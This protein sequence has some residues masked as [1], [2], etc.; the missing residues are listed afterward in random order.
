[1]KKLILLFLLIS[2]NVASQT[3]DG[4]IDSSF[5]NNG[6]A[7]ANFNGGS[8]GLSFK[9][10]SDKNII[11]CGQYM[12]D[13]NYDFAAIKFDSIGKID[14]SFGLNGKFIY[15]FGLDDYANS[16]LIQNDN[17]IVLGGFSSTWDGF[18]V[19]SIFNQ[20]SLLRIHNN[21][22]IDSSFG[23]NGKFELDFNPIDC[24]AVAISMQSN[25]KII[26]VG[27]YID[28]NGIQVIAIRLTQNGILDLS[29]GN[30]GITKIVLD[31]LLKEDEAT[32]VVVQQDDKILISVITFDQS[33][34][35]RIFGLVRL[36][37][38]GNLDIS[39]GNNGIVKTDIPNQVN[40]YV[41][42]SALQSDGKIL[43]AGTCKNNKIMAICRYNI[44]GTLDPT[45]GDQ[46]I[47]TLN[48]SLGKDIIRDVI[49]QDD[50]RIIIV[51]ETSSNACILR[52]TQFGQIDSTFNN[53]GINHFGNSTGETFNNVLLMNPSK[54]VAGGYAHDS[55][56]IFQFSAVAFNSILFSGINSMVNYFEDF[57]IYPN[58]SNH[59]LNFSNFN[60]NYSISLFD[61]TGKL[62]SNFNLSSDQH[63]DISTLANGIYFIQVQSANKSQT[64]KFIK[65]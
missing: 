37:E 64:L 15:D 42:A 63:L 23:N 21:G 12:G 27:K 6:A 13:L 44:Q 4:I 62:I 41:L 47:D 57:K 34:P 7:F 54:I 38:N 8:N 58:P 30:A 52:L 65:E 20:F 25:G 48:I 10:D 43:Q 22:T 9:L 36:N 31:T 40:D 53:T 24:G 16:L 3:L 14:T 18:N 56:G 45:F 32:S 1:M 2:L 55:S 19:N 49:V 11:A 5:G 59:L 29:F 33:F 51:G 26:V 50:K 39:F 17:K 60:S 61:F 46:G 35:G 28:G